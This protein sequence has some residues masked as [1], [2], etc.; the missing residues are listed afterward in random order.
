MNFHI[1]L[2]SVIAVCVCI[3]VTHQT[4]TRLNSVTTFE[5]INEFFEEL[6]KNQSN[7]FCDKLNISSIREKSGESP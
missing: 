6:V 4:V 3:D 2:F 1:R 5:G 7:I